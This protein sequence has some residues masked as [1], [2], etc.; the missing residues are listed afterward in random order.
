MNIKRILGPILFLAFFSAVFIWADSY[1]RLPYPLSSTRV[2]IPDTNVS[3]QIPEG[4]LYN[5]TGLFIFEDPYETFA[6]PIFL[7]N[8]LAIE[9]LNPDIYPVFSSPEQ[10]IEY[11]F[12][13]NVPEKQ[14]IREFEVYL[15]PDDRI[16]RPDTIRYMGLI[17]YG[18]EQYIRIDMLGASTN[19]NEVSALLEAVLNSM[20]I[21]E[22]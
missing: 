16:S 13:G 18:D 5:P 7:L 21:E 20:R 12:R 22:K 8:N 19:A 3:V 15:R 1:S 14:I 17:L 11:F 10:T 2:V 9:S 6:T 4:L